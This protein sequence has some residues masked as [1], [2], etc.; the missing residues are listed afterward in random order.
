MDMFF[1]ELVVDMEKQKK[2]ACTVFE[3]PSQVVQDFVHQLYV[4]I[5]MIGMS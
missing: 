4:F 3:K 5:L 2:V 1:S